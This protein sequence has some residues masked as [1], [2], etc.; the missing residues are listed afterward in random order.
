MNA[1]VNY[2]DTRIEFSLPKGWN[3]ISG[4][5]KP[6]APGVP[7]P[8]EE[9]RRALDHPIGSPKI[10]EL[11]ARGME[12]V[13]LF[14]DLQRPTPAHL[15]FPEVLD[16][17][18]RAGVPDERIKALCALGT[19]V[20][21]SLEQMRPKVGEAA[22][23]R[24]QGRLF[25]HDPHASDNVIIGKTHRG[26]LVEINRHAAAADL[27]IGIG[28]CMPHP[29]AGYG[30]GFKILMPGISSYRSVADHHFAWMRHPESRVNRLDGNYYWE[31]IVD[32]GRIG[33]LAFKIDS[34]INHRREIVRAFAGD[35]LEQQKEA[36]RYA[37]KLYLVPLPKLA[38]VTITSA[39]PL[40]IGVQAT[41]ALAMS[42]FCTR[43]GGSII[44]IAPQK[45]AGP[46]MPLIR[47]MASA[48]TASDFHR[49]LIA[50]DV[51]EHLR[52]FGISYI[53]QVV[54]FKAMTERFKVFHVTEGLSPEQVRMMKFTYCPSVQEA[55]DQVAREMPGA[56][57]AVFPSGGNIIPAVA[58]K[59]SR[60][61]D[62]GHSNI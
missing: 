44:W 36:S 4:E 27:I 53:M 24:L 54:F 38:D 29:T 2:G 46:I 23:K 59:R 15:V 58:Q 30:G 57:V 31:E 5:D 28:E 11:A 32:A 35:P 8:L 55:V 37:E 13:V 9:V 18:N 50:G 12:V 22:F 47:E 21:L 48:E 40:E 6:P 14:D 52:Q 25:C 51:P 43:T 7:N 26:T 19:H 20:V 3:L 45:E 56:D 42:K 10:E 34:I 39:F 61:R 16:R 41:K 17:L 60:G 62:E 33:R 49:R 1:S